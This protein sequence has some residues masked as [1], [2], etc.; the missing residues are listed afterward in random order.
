MIPCS[1]TTATRPRHTGPT[2][3]RGI[4]RTLLALA[5]M[6]LG[7]AATLP[8]GTAAVT[9]HQV[10]A[11]LR[12]ITVV[13][14]QPHGPVPLLV[15]LHG[16]DQS[17]AEFLAATGLDTL[18]DTKGIALALPQVRPGADDPLGCW[19]WWQPPNQRRD[20]PEPAAI[21]AVTRSMNIA[22][23]PSRIYVAGLSSG[24]AMAMILATVYPDV[25]AAAGVHSGVGFAAA[26]DAACAV[27]V[28][29]SV[30]AD[31]EERGQLAYLHQASHRIVPV[32]I[33]QGRADDVVDPSNADALVRE[34]A[35]TNDFV[36]DGNGGNDSFDARPDDIEEHRGPCPAAEGCYAYR[37]ERFNDR[38]GRVAME[39][40]TV[41]GLGHAWAGG[42][43]GHK[44]A[45]PR[46][47]NADAM[48]W[49]FLDAYRLDPDSLQAARPH[50]CHDWWGAPWWQYLWAGTMSFSE[51][52][53]DM[54]PWTTV[55]RHTID[56]VSGPGRC[57]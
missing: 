29:H 51:Y 16:C 10:V 24:A 46:G 5:A 20:G 40:V 48:L 43:A 35:Q 53:C 17:A 47:P 31:P 54:N 32:I 39:R 28:L 26:G 33:I 44:Y 34:I 13:P 7:Q 18:V 6:L 38:D 36:D 15:A 21:V 45:D 56:G 25:F 49:S 55:W 27:S 52:L 42:R 57:P 37:V 23:D 4:R 14:D 11:G 12:V 19:R 3:S 8:A 1:A 2:T 41:E 50:E 9:D 22:I 30:A